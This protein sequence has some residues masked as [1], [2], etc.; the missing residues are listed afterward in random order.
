MK[1]TLYLVGT[2]IGNLADITLRAL[3]TLKSVD[4]I[5]CEDTRHSLG[6]LNFYEI[7]KPLFACHQHN[8]R[9]TCSKIAHMLDDGQNIALITDAGMPAISD[10]GAVV[11]NFLFE[12][13]YKVEVIP[14]ATAVASAMALSGIC[15]P[16]W[17]FVGFLP[18]KI[19]DKKALLE[20]FANVK[21]ALV[22]YSSPHDINKDC[23]ALFKVL[24]E[25]KVHIVKE[26][27]K[28]HERHEIY[29]LG[30]CHIDEPKGEY[31]IIV[32]QN[33]QEAQQAE[34]LPLEEQLQI[35]LDGG[36]EKKEAIKKVAKDN[37][38]PKDVVYKLSF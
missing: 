19:K 16:I 26:I 21:T 25:R 31:V 6:M 4:A 14:G 9:E 1:G 18:S 33:Q 10:P 38:V 12:Q 24:G 23:E 3:E 27:T 2:P 5:A 30:E 29:N 8:E 7:K 36:M 20:S 37:N 15:Q 17:T 22:I 35:L 13:G 11:V 34:P 32:E 28:I